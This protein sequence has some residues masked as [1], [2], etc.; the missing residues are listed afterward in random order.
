MGSPAD[1]EM[2]NVDEVAAYVGVRPATVY[3]WCQEGR[4]GCLKIGK[5]WRIRREALDDLLRRA[6][7]GDTLV[8]RLASFLTV[9][10][11]VLAVAETEALLHRLD[12]AFFGVARARGGT[13]VKFYGAGPMCAEELRAELMR[14]GLDVAGLEREGRFRISPERDRLRGRADVLRRL[15]AEAEEG[16]RGRTVWASFDWVERVDPEE[17]L[18]Q[19][20]ALAEVAD[21]GRLVVKMGVLERMEEEWP[22]AIDR[23]AQALRRGT[24]RVSEAGL[25]LTRA[26]PLPPT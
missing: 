14:N 25:V 20:E 9:P 11:H 5:A 4:L 16:G 18:R 15:L 8:G 7:R 3:Q 23:R 26:M 2:L 6:E 13:L 19:H 17:A 21:T 22:P 1:K 10:D 24:I 12:A